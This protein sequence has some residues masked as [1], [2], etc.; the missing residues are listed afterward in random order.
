MPDAEIKTAKAAVELTKA[1]DETF[2][3]IEVG[4]RKI[5][6]SL[7]NGNHGPAVT[8]ILT[9]WGESHFRP[10]GLGKR[11][12]IVVTECL[13]AGVTTLT[14]L[15]IIAGSIYMI[16][17]HAGSLAEG[18]GMAIGAGLLGGCVRYFKT[19]R[20]AMGKLF[21]GSLFQ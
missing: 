5:A 14:L 8:D 7:S 6:L 13:I 2:L 19:S 11:A 12:L 18:F 17:T 10:Q 21:S 1:G 4:G 15:A 16:Y 3:N 20:R 9:E